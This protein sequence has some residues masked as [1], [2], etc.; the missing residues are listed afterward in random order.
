MLS[1]CLVLHK[2]PGHATGQVSLMRLS[3]AHLEMFSVGWRVRGSPWKTVTLSLEFH[4]P[5]HLDRDFPHKPHKSATL[6]LT[7]TSNMSHMWQY[8]HASIS[9][10]P[11]TSDSLARLLI[12]SPFMPRRGFG[13]FFLSIFP[14]TLF[15]SFPFPL[16]EKSSARIGHPSLCGSNDTWGHLKSEPFPAL[17]VS[18]GQDHPSSYPHTVFWNQRYKWS[19]GQIEIHTAATCSSLSHLSH[20]QAMFWGHG[21]RHEAIC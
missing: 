11:S 14:I 1:Q 17:Q 21:K 10:P 5:L 2:R 13:S 7:M 4:P 6:H 9:Q 12:S 3:A 20:L 16:D 18:L 8:L 19:F 15:S